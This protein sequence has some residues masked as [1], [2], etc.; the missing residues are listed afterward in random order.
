MKDWQMDWRME[1]QAMASQ[2]ASQMNTADYIDPYAFHIDQNTNKQ[3]QKQKEKINLLIKMFSEKQED[4]LDHHP[5]ESEGTSLII[6]CN[7]P[8][9]GEND[10]KSG[11]ERESLTQE[12]LQTHY[13]RVL[14]SYVHQRL[15]WE[16]SLEWRAGIFIQYTGGREDNIS[17]ATGIYSTNY[18]AE[19]E[20]LK[21]AAAHIEVSTHASHSVVL[22]TDALS[23]Q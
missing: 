10:S 3:K 12:Y 11:P 16:C 18:K 2:P 1:G 21:T 22:L 4:I 13:P 8:G 9:V 7:I 23:I 20:A 14:D 5:K 6:R 19:T 17:L 15:C